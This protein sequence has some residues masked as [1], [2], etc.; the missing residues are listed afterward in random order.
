MLLL[1][2][3][4]C[5][6]LLSILYELVQL[7]SDFK[8]ELSKLF[9]SV[10]CM[11]LEVLQEREIPFESRGFLHLLCETSSSEITF[12]RFLPV[13]CKLVKTCSKKEYSK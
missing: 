5:I 9:L 3:K 8:Y 2:N 12:R 10:D 1:C 11:D 7:E 6:I 13:R 4:Y